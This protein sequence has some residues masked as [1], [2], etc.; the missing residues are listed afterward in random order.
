[1]KLVVVPESSERFTGVTLRSGSVAPGLSAAMAGSFHLV[2]A[3]LK[4]FAIVDGERFSDLTPSMLKM[5]AIGLM[6]RGRSYAS[7]PPQRSLASARSSSFS[8]ESEPANSTPPS[9]NAV[10]PPPEPIGS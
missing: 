7:P 3:P 5:T 2:I 10:R 1:V 9:M 8:A 4:I 6:Y